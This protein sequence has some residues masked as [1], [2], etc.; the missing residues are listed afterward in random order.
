M[1]KETGLFG[2]CL[3]QETVLVVTKTK[4]KQKIRRRRQIKARN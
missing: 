2:W 1:S 4:E 3:P